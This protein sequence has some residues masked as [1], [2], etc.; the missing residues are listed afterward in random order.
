MKNH[1]IS[2][3]IKKL[4]EQTHKIENINVIMDRGDINITLE[5]K[6]NKWE[7]PCV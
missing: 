1:S 3:F 5:I 6:K 7:K 2:A 4:L